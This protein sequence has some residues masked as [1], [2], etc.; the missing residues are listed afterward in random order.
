MQQLNP[1]ELVDKGKQVQRFPHDAHQDQLTSSRCQ[2]IIVI[3][4]FLLF[5][6]YVK[7]NS[8][9]PHPRENRKR[10][11]QGF[12]TVKERR[13]VFTHRQRTVTL[14]LQKAGRRPRNVWSRTNGERIRK[15]CLRPSERTDFTNC[16][17]QVWIPH[18]KKT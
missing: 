9:C 7:Q 1:D 13:K 16:K 6:L 5:V 10:S 18:N 12:R 8:L 2:P 4:R 15:S 3:N 14:S 17:K 11:K